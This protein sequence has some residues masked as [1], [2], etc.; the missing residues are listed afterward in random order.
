MSDAEAKTRK[1]ALVVLLIL[2]VAIASNEARAD[3]IFGAD[4]KLFVGGESVIGD[5]DAVQAGFTFEWTYF[6]ID[7]S[8]GR[9]RVQWRVPDEP[10]WQMDDWQSGSTVT[11]RIYPFQTG[12]LRPLVIWSHSSDVTRGD[13]FND[14]EEPTSD[15]IG[16]GATYRWNSVDVDVAYG[17]Q[18]RECAVFDCPSQNK[19]N[20]VFVRLRWNFLGDN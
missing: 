4:F 14:K 3:D 17:M 11:A 19:T 13:P 8:H 9:K 16:A 6:A 20:E 1:A 15:F 2:F 12:N 5:L 18:A 7:M 10:Q